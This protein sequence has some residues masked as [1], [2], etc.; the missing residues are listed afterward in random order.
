MDPQ[1]WRRIEELYHA[2]SAIEPERWEAYVTAECAGDE[3][4][5][6][7]VLSLLGASGEADSL[8]QAEVGR[9]AATVV[10]VKEAAEGERIGSYRVLRPLGRGGMGA[11]Y[12]AERA[13]DTYHKQVAIKLVRAGLG[14]EESLRRFRAERQ[15]L[16]KLEH[17]HIARLLDGG[18]SES[19]QPY[20][21][22]EYV[23]GKPLLEYCREKQLSLRARLALFQQICGAVQYAHQNLIVHRDIKPGNVL[24]SSEGVAKLVDFGIAKLLADDPIASTATQSFERLLTPEYA[25]PEQVRG[26]AISTA[27]DVYSLGAL[28]YELLT[29]KPPLEFPSRTA[30]DVERVITTQQPV[31][32]SIRGGN[33][34]LAG[35][36]D[37]IALMALR[38]EPARRYVSAAALAE[39][40]QRYLDGY[41]VQARQEGVLYL[42]AKFMR[43]NRVGVGA[44]AVFLVL[45]AG[46]VWTVVRERNTANRERMK[47]EQVSKFLVKSFE[48]ASPSEARGKQVTAREILDQGVSRL[49]KDLHNQPDVQAT[50]M[51]TIAEVYLSLGLVKDSIALNAR[52]IE[53]AKKAGRQESVEMADL[54]SQRSYLLREGGQY[55]AAKEEMQQAF[56]LLGRVA[57]KDE[58]R[59]AS[60]LRSYGPLLYLMNESAEAEKVLREALTLRRRVS[61]DDHDEV[62][63]NLGNLARALVNQRKYEEALPY[64]QEA[65]RLGLRRNG[66][67]SEAT[68]SAYNR[69]GLTQF[70]LRKGEES[71]VSFRKA[72]AIGRKLYG[73]EHKDIAANLNGLGAALEIAGKFD[74]AADAHR[75][76]I[77]IFRKVYGGNHPV[78]A[79]SLIT[80][81]SCLHYGGLHAEE[82]NVAQESLAMVLATV[83]KEDN[84]FV[85]ANICVA[86]AKA[87]QGDFEEAAKRYGEG[88]RLR[89]AKSNLRDETTLG[90]LIQWASAAR[91]MGQCAQIE[92]H[93]HEAVQENQDATATVM[94]TQ[95]DEARTLLAACQIDRGQSGEAEGILRDV[96]AREEKNRMTRRIFPVVRH[97]LGRLLLLQGNAAEAEPLL[98]AAFE[99]LRNVE[100]FPVDR[101]LNQLAYARCLRALQRDAGTMEREARQTLQPVQRYPVVRA[102]LAE[103]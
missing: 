62:V 73:P 16:A 26:E 102:A 72:I 49:D 59:R 77:A 35:D 56:A 10:G 103:R 75:Q 7:E 70:Y 3:G 91:I 2:A 19:G 38:K 78:L 21:V 69:I 94:K 5:R 58:D 1:R 24:V 30:L 8:L 55:K 71:A 50:L 89:K 4:L 81:S 27:S 37:N 80:F 86:R 47:A 43:R 87:D 41:P 96:L 48:L 85:S 98:Q 11:V 17:T 60:Y 23:D 90:Y 31:A 63:W 34:V 9:A 28:L 82:A 65:L 42:T 83:G 84:R 29:G 67:I 51:N 97:H 45:L 61:G 25:S 79:Q 39:D 101:A 53:Q 36:L 57:K 66:E 6:Q 68:M 33:R 99:K 20:V 44:A 22:M 92:P 74:E 100:Y 93:L 54:L 14:G 46:F 15:I 95:R 18:A 76:S 52:A 88:F 32:P 12:L 64:A 13:D 40:I